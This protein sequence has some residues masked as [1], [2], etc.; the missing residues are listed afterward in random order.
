M[1]GG[2]SVA[3]HAQI[4]RTDTRTKEYHLFSLLIDLGTLW[5]SLSLS[6]RA[7]QM[8][9]VQESSESLVAQ[10]RREVHELAVVAEQRLPTDI[11]AKQ[12]RL[13]GLQKVLTETDNAEYEVQRLTGELNDI[14]REIQALAD[15]KMSTQVYAHAH[16]CLV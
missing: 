13:Q 6:V 15:K 1:L 4:T 12:D 9:A 3:A 16:L 7:I 11:A 8:N 14:T 10:L 5:R 2:K